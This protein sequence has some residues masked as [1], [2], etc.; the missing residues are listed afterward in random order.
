MR[1]HLFSVGEETEKTAQRGKRSYVW[2]S[3]SLGCRAEAEQL[4][5]RVDV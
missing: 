5:Y 1:G 3:E 2:I 4:A